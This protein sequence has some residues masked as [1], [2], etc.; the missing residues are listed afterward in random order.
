MP[1]AEAQ[2]AKGSEIHSYLLRAIEIQEILEQTCHNVSK[3]SF[4]SLST[5]EELREEPKSSFD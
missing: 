1:V 4:Q 5:I 3:S 2:A